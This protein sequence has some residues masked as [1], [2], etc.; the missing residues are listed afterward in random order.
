MVDAFSFPT[1]RYILIGKIGKPHGLRGEVRLHLYSEQPENL[2]GYKRLVL[3]STE[4][5]LS[6]PLRLLSSRVQGKAA[7][8]ELESI[9][10]RNGADRLKGMGV[11]VE[12][13]ELPDTKEDEYYYYQYTGLAVKTVEGLCLGRVE[14]IFSNGAQDI[15]VIRG[16][17]REY[18]IPI[19]KSVIIRRTDE[20]LIVAPPPGLLEINSGMPDAEDD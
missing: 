15:L 11:L 12:K 16:A 5:I 2:Q 10:E 19:L 8:V 1:D 6:R 9:S 20:E 14:N 4:G 3:A 17:G 18:L 7:I 13:T